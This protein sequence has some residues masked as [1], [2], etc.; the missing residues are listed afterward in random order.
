MGS[1]LDI[2]LVF[3][4]SS[5]REAKC[6]TPEHPRTELGSPAGIQTLVRFKIHTAYMLEGLGFGVG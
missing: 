2:V 6:H 4:V 1:L 3:R 5:R